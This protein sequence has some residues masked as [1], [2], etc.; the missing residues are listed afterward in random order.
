MAQDSP[1][2]PYLAVGISSTVHG[3]GTREDIMANL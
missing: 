3:I 1:V 2:S